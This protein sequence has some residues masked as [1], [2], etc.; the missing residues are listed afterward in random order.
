MHAFIGVDVG[1]ASARAGVFDRRGTLLATARQPIM[2]WHA[3]GDI[4]EQSSEDIWRACAQ[5]IRAAM[6]E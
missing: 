6:Q 5:A 3:P 2:V 1:T 4:V